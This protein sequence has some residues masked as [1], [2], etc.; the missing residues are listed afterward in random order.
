[1]PD[2]AD[3][4]SDDLARHHVVKPELTGRGHAVRTRVKDGCELDRLAMKGWINPYQ[5]SAGASLSRDLHG[6]RLLG[7]KTTSFGQSISGGTPGEAQNTALDR[8]GDAIRKLDFIV[9]EPSCWR[10]ARGWMP[11]CTTTTGARPRC[12]AART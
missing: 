7:V 8:V 1:M 10:C 6:A 4:G 12:C 11:W 2:R 3:Y 5:H 9:G